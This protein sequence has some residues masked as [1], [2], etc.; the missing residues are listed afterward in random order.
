M[1]LDPILG[2]HI[3]DALPQALNICDDYVSY[4]GSSHRV[5]LSLLLSPE[6]LFACVVLLPT[7]VLLLPSPS[8]LLFVNLFCILLMAHLGYLH[9]TKASLRC[10]NSSLRGSGV[11]HA[12]L[13]PTGK[14]T[15]DTVLG[16]EIM[17]TIPLQV[18]VNVSGLL[19]HCIT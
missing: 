9:L 1:C 13:V 7:W 4:I 5:V 11:V 2:T 16:R 17:V 14:C 10:C 6:L 12:V 19:V 18:L 8:Q 15:Y 3:L